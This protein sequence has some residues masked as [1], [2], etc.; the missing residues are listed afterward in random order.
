MDNTAL[1]HAT[2]VW[3]SFNQSQEPPDSPFRITAVSKAAAILAAATLSLF[4][5][6]SS[7]YGYMRPTMSD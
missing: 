2:E 7:A 6:I 5:P 3:N 1:F 4:L